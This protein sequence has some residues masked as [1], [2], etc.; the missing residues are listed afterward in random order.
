MLAD[1]TPESDDE[2]PEETLAKIAKL[3][4]NEKRFTQI[5]EEEYERRRFLKSAIVGLGLSSPPEIDL[6]SES[7]HAAASKDVEESPEKKVKKTAVTK[8]VP[9]SAKKEPRP[10]PVHSMNLRSRPGRDPA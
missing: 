4:E 6:H 1:R 7:S 3:L 9:S 2:N 5:P 10:K 8:S